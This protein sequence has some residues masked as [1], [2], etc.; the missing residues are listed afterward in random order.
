MHYIGAMSSVPPECHVLTTPVAWT[1]AAGRIVGSNPAFAHWLGVSLRRLTGLPLAAFEADGDSLARALAAP[2]D[3]DPPSREFARLRR[4]ALAFPGQ[5]TP[6][7]A[8]VHLTRTASGW[9]LEA[10]PVEEFPGEDPAVAL[11]SALSAALKGL[12]HELRNPLAGLKGA[13]QLLARR[14]HASSEDDRDSRELV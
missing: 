9:L 12:A 6:R 14:L 5:E 4:L 1:D 8:D 11:P 13:A 10:H 7:F 3:A 2:A